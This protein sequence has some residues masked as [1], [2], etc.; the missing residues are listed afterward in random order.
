MGLELV[1]A[2]QPPMENQTLREHPAL[3]RA[4]SPQPT[5]AALIVG[6][7]TASAALPAPVPNSEAP[8][9][10][11]APPG[12]PDVTTKVVPKLRVLEAPHPGDLSGCPKRF[13]LFPGT[14]AIFS[15][16]PRSLK[17][18]KVDSQD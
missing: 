4:H 10:Q 2:S 5:V 7:R 12:F 18:K 9:A 1:P 6:L 15:S 14:K 13:L 17:K 8:S 11:P 16:L 3:S